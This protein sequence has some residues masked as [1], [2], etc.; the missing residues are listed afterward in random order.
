MLFAINTQRLR[1]QS[2]VVVENTLPYD[3]IR[4]LIG[5]RRNFVFSHRQCNC[6][7][8]KTIRTIVAHDAQ[9]LIV[10]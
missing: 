5:T 1:A 2:G 4:Q 10:E 3:L 7:P 9:R 8:H 6:L